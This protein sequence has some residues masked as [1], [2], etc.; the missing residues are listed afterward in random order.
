MHFTSDGGF[1]TCRLVSFRLKPLR[2]LRLLNVLLKLFIFLL[3]HLINFIFRVLREASE[4]LLGLL[5]GLLRL[6][7]EDSLDD[8]APQVLQR[9]VPPLTGAL[10]LID[11]RQLVLPCTNVQRL[12]RVNLHVARHGQV[13]QVRDEQVPVDLTR[14]LLLHGGEDEIAAVRLCDVSQ[15]HAE[16][17]LDLSIIGIGER[18]ELRRD[19]RDWYEHQVD[20][21][22][23]HVFMAAPLRT[24]IL[25]HF[26]DSLRVALLQVL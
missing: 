19:D 23:L 7:L 17:L 24:Q 3:A 25:F 26:V 15:R 6:A 2:T 18:I 12:R 16:L 9:V 20:L 5:G 14:Q 8:F 21:L 10:R 1:L 22:L 13:K 11:P 4:D